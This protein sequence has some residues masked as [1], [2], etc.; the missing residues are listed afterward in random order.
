MGR[1]FGKNN[2]H[3]VGIYYA[4]M[5]QRWRLFY[6]LKYMS[7]VRQMLLLYAFYMPR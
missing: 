1:A 6:L 2:Y 3:F 5:S 7:P 4:T